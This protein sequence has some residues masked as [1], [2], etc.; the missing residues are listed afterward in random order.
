MVEFTLPIVLQIL[1]TA[2]LFVGIIYYITIMRNAQKTRDLSLRAQELTLKAQ[3]QAVET[4]QAQLFMQLND[5]WQLMNWAKIMPHISEKISG[6]KELSE[7]ME[8]D[9]EFRQT[10]SDLG[11]FYEYLGVIVKEGYLSIRLVALMWA[12]VTRTFWENIA[13][14]MLEEMR[15]ATGYPRGWSETEYLCRELIRYMDEH[16]ELK[17]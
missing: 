13:E 8:S 11:S 16:P 17:T 10:I 7:R 1:Q 14:P 12:G 15:E 2:A 9:P 5:R 4:R 6:Y 3:E